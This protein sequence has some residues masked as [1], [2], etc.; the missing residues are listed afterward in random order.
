MGYN[1]TGFNRQHEIM[2]RKKDRGEI[3]YEQYSH[4][5]DTNAALS[6]NSGKRGAPMARHP[7]AWERIARAGGTVVVSGSDG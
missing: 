4:W 5:Y 7:D 3:S 6:T 2:R 1:V